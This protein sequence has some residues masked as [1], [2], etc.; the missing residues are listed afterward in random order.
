MVGVSPRRRPAAAH[1]E[2]VLAPALVSRALD[3]L[4]LDLRFALRGLCRN[5]TFTVVASI[6]IAVGMA[7]TTAMFSLTNAILL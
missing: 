1:P 7:A 3:D 6:T 5:P 2:G 4:R